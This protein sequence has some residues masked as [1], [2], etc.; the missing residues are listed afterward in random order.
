MPGLFARAARWVVRTVRRPGMLVPRGRRGRVVAL[1]VAIAVAG[2]AASPIAIERFTGLPDDAAFR[3]GDRVVTEQELDKRI[4]TL[5]ALY[6]L[7]RPTDDKQQQDQ[8]RRDSAKAVAVSIILKRVAAQRDIHVSDKTARDRLNTMIEQQMGDGGRKQFARLLGE[9]G[10]SEKN[11]LQEIK[12]HERTSQLMEQVTSDVAKVTDKEVRQAYQDRQDEM[13]KPE[14]RH[15][16]NIVVEDEDQARELLQQAKDGADFADL[17]EQ[18][19]LDQATR[20][21][22]G[23]LGAVTRAQ[24]QDPYAKAAF[25]AE[26]GSYFGPVETQ[27]GWNIG[28]VVKVQ[29]ARELDFDEAAE[30]LKATLASERELTAWHKWLAKQIKDVDVE[31]ADKYRP[32]DPDAPPESSPHEP[33]MNTQPNDNGTR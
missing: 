20:A 32:D 26:Q 15:L 28:Q 7:Q 13:V 31:Y 19:S 17:A 4:Q 29:P 6:G 33:S 8:F 23:N 16:R 22:G 2:G 24:L 14:Q 30:D 11:V 5:G 25:D 12:L 3:V 27:H 18:H 10:A 21:D 1:V 9:I